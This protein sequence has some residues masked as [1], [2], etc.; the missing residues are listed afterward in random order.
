MDILKDFFRNIYPIS[1]EEEK[2]LIEGWTLKK[3][4]KKEIISSAGKKEKYI[5]FVLKGVQRGYYLKE[6]KEFTVVFTYPPSFCGSVDSLLSGQPSDYFIES[7]TDSVLVRRRYSEITDLAEK[8]TGINN[9]LRKA[10][11][12]AF[13]GVNQKN[14]ELLALSMEEKFNVFYKRSAHLINLVPHKYIASYLGM[15]PT[16][17]SKVL[18][19]HKA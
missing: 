2:F 16:N 6:G 9:L 5:Y 17:F 11:E 4:R 3:Y 12:R 10:T 14:F 19:N 18:K 8:H 15:D 13:L 1:Q 7:I